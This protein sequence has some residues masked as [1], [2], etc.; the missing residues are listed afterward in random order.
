MHTK[1]NALDIINEF[2]IRLFSIS[3]DRWMEAGLEAVQFTW[4]LYK[5][6]QLQRTFSGRARLFLRQLHR[7]E[8]SWVM[9]ML[10]D[11]VKLDRR[12]DLALRV[13]E[14]LQL[15]PGGLGLESVEEVIRDLPRVARNIY[16][17]L[18]SALDDVDAGFGRP[19]AVPLTAPRA[20]A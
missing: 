6:Y 13:L 15:V 12:A 18:A 14:A 11:V 20:A 9:G 4:R 17:V 1:K 10:R 5:A 8:L 2:L 3:A 16:N 19:R 7:E